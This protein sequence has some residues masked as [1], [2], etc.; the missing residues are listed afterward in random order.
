MARWIIQRPQE[1]SHPSEIRVAEKLRELDEQWTVL[2][3]FYYRDQDGTEREGDFL[4]IGPADGILL[5]EVKSSLPRW[6]SATGRREGEKDSPINQLMTQWQAIVAVIKEEG[7]LTWVGKALW[8][9][10]QSAPVEQEQVEGI[11]RSLLVLEND[12]EH[13]LHHVWLRIFGRKVRFPA[14]PASLRCSPSTT[15]FRLTGQ[16]QLLLGNS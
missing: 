7:L 8:E 2:W 1:H 12:L 6:F 5:L 16:A 3:G 14:H 13:W 4:I 11:P 15:S 10:N 9:P